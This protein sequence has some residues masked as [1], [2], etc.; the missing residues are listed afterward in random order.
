[1]A[2]RLA[3]W[4]ACRLACLHTCLLACWQ[5]CSHAELQFCNLTSYSC[6]Y[7][8]PHKL[9]MLAHHENGLQVQILDLLPC[10]NPAN[11]SFGVTTAFAIGWWNRTGYSTPG[12]APSRNG[13]IVYK[14]CCPVFL[15][16]VAQIGPACTQFLSRSMMPKLS[17]FMCS[18]GELLSTTCGHEFT[19]ECSALQQFSIFIFLFHF[20][21]F[22]FFLAVMIAA[23]TPCL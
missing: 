5:T 13:A 17:L 1:M 9:C 11:E 8:R 4:L 7:S 10:P 22:I 6:T 14:V 15:V 23:R 20:I 18:S 12:Y 19:F 21:F 16:P 3:C 2:S